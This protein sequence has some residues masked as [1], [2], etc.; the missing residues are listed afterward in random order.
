MFTKYLLSVEKQLW[1]RFKA[2]CY[3]NRVTML[4][5]IREFIKNYVRG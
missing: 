3:A 2:K 5:A 4:D 1:Q